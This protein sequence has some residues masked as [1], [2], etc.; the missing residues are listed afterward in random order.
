MAKVCFF[1][2]ALFFLYHTGAVAFR[3]AFRGSL[4]TPRPSTVLKANGGS[5]IP[6]VSK[7]E[8]K[9]LLEKGM[10]E[11]GQKH[12]LLDVRQQWEAREHGVIGDP[13]VVPH[14][15][16]VDAFDMDDDAFAS[17]YGKPKPSREEVLVIYCKAGTRA[18]MVADPL[19]QMGYDV[20]VYSGSFMDWFGYGYPM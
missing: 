13:V 15:E 16:V 20:K 5:G 14:T 6:V 17:K 12:V 1:S 11:N 2:I 18:A 19:A 9:S 4:V 8:V 10:E 7:E 3:M